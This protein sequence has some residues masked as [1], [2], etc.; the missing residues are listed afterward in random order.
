MKVLLVEDELSSL[1][2]LEQALKQEGIDYRTATDGRIGFD[3]FKEFQPEFILSDINMS[4]MSGIELLE[5]VKMIKPET[6]VVMLTSYNSEQY[7]VD[8]MKHGANNYLKKPI[9]KDTFLTFLR[10]YENIIDMYDIDRKVSS[11]QS[12][13]SFTL[14]FPTNFDIIPSIVNLL[15]SETDGI[16]TN[17]KQLD[18]RLGLSELLLNAVEHGNLGITFFEKTDAI[19][20]DTL[21][22]VYAERLA[23]TEMVQRNVEV[24]YSCQN[25]IC[26]WVI[27][28]QG[29]GFDFKSIPDP[30][31]EEGLQR[32]HGR[33]IFICKFQFDVMDY[34][35][36]GNQVKVI[37]KV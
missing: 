21:Q 13:H 37:K 20:N 25:G 18:I 16:L 15:V 22:N 19:L 36:C 24:R 23:I 6:I 33:G 5:K 31:S 11:F 34:L 1:R 28:D 2:Y 35:G 14:V 7:V 3:I 26:E 30:S 29:K 12:K 27:T 4:E 8:A 9:L 32:P 17:E 10:K